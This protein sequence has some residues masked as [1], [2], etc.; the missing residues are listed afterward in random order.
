M[1]D[2]LRRRGDR[3]KKARRAVPRPL[4][5]GISVF[6]PFSAP[7][8]IGEAV[9][10]TALV[11]G[12]AGIPSACHADGDHPE[13]L[14]AFA[15]AEPAYDTAI[16]FN[17]PSAR[18][19]RIARQ[20]ADRRRIGIWY[21][22]L[23]VFPPAWAAPAAAV[24]EVWA[25][26]R[27]IAGAVEAATRLPARLVPHAATMEPADRDAARDSLGLPR[28]RRIVL[29]V[30]DLGVRMT[31]KNPDAVLRAFADAFPPGSDAPLLLVKYHQG[32]RRT[33]QDEVDATLARIAAAPNVRV[34]DRSVSQDEMRIICSAADAF[35]S[36]HRSEGFGFNIFDMM[37]IGRTC[38]ATNFS[39]NVDFMSA[40][41][42]IPIPWTM[43]A[44]GGDEYPYGHGQWW[45]EP[46]HD[47]AVAAPR[48]VGTASDDALAALGARARADTLRDFSVERVAGI[49]RAIW[50]GMPVKEPQP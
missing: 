18:L 20:L 16:L 39:G 47:A 22:E 33:D 15:T 10:R 11:V 32:Y 9:R 24:D 2:W 1:F 4:A 38:I 43:R 31:R 19:G 42:S 7:T 44:V 36:L 14:R 45:A 17:S 49:V 23:P 3:R 30:F 29:T 13:G 50:D 27:F 34:I 8:G 37:T 21:W 40:G 6:G 25:P 12:A 28:S 41:N 26:T 35:I 5:H 46:D 48:F